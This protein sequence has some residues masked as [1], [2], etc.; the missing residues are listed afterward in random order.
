MKTGIFTIATL[1]LLG[2]TSARPQPYRVQNERRAAPTNYVT[3]NVPKVLVWIDRD[4]K[5]F[6]TQT[7]TMV[8]TTYGVPQETAQSS[9]NS[10]HDFNE[11]SQLPDP[12]SDPSAPYLAAADVKDDQPYAANAN[13]PRSVNSASKNPPQPQPSKATANRV[14]SSSQDTYKT[15][16]P[17]SNHPLKNGLGMSYSP[18]LGDGGCKS[19]EEVDQDISKMGSY[20]VIR[21]YGVDCEQVPKIMSAAKKHNKK[22]FAGV[23]DINNLD[24]DLETLIDGAKSSWSS[25]VTVSI[26]NE[27]VNGG[28]ASVAS[29]V[30]AVDKARSTLRQAGYT[31]PVVTVDTFGA[32]IN[33]P[34]LC[35]ASD[36][37]A[38]N[39]HAFFNPNTDASA[40]GEFVK[41]QAK[42]VSVAAGGNKK[43]VITESGWPKAGKANGKA[44]PSR[45]NQRKAIQSLMNAFGN[46]DEAGLILFSAFDDPWKK[47][48]EYSFGTEKFWGIL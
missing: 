27:L 46:D 47:D 3:V 34:E 5:P 18:Y 2:A 33:N 31:G 21:F 30:Q 28:K 14:P 7:I 36:Y 41:N 20:N 12:D 4:G 38:A 1:S 8:S 32:L 6:S 10:D 43:T 44:V 11:K 25:I 15:A 37:C 13:D 16:Q 42:L 22:V 26:G 17:P 29:V 39:C 48:N 19:E 40:A 45:E 35:W 24:K 23:F 9:L